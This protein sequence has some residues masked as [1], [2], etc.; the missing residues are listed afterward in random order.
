[1]AVASATNQPTKIGLIQFLSRRICD[2]TQKS[3]F[4]KTDLKLGPM[5]RISKYFFQKGSAGKSRSL[6]PCDG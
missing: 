4:I 5:L 2:T 1:M 6:P 3:L